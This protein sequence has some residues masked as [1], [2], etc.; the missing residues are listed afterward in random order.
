MKTHWI[1][2]N[3][4][5]QY[6]TCIDVIDIKIEEINKRSPEELEMFCDYDVLENLI[7][8]GFVL[9]QGSISKVCGVLGIKKSYV[10]NENKH[11][12]IINTAANYWKHHNE[13]REESTYK[14]K[15]IKEFRTFGVELIDGYPLLNVL[16]KLT[17]NQKFAFNVLLKEVSN[18][19]DEL[20]SRKK[21]EKTKKPNHA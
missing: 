10:F 8:M 19:V 17:K 16:Y 11:I 7:G 2:G 18:F 14:E 21:S 9:L 4:E 1:L 12:E 15:Y 6:K 3:L 20:V 13:W 5:S